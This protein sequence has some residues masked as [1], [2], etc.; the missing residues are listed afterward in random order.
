MRD[1]LQSVR[2]L[3]GEEVKHRE[4]LAK[5]NKHLKNELKRAQEELQQKPRV[6]VTLPPKVFTER[7]IHQRPVSLRRITHLPVR[8]VIGNLWYSVKRT[9]VSDNK[10]FWPL[11]HSYAFCCCIIFATNIPS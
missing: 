9:S 1:D 8:L 3:L 7:D 11:Y 5:E 2:Q 10:S 4:R 6:S